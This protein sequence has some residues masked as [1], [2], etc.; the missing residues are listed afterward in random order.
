MRR[1]VRSRFRLH[2]RIAISETSIL[3]EFTVK[4]T[5]KFAVEPP[6]NVGLDFCYAAIHDVLHVSLFLLR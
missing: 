5:R 3:F 6:V 1:N 2:P 4:S